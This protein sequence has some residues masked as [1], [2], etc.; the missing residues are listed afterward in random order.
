MKA[1][2]QR[3]K[4]WMLLCVAIL[5]HVLYICFNVFKIMIVK[6]EDAPVAVANCIFH[7]WEIV[8]IIQRFIA[9]GDK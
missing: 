2:E 1:S 7:I 9:K 6:S 5:K 8:E 4:Q 3:P